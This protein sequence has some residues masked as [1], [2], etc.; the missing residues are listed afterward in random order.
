MGNDIEFDTALC[1]GTHHVSPVWDC[2]IFS[3]ADTIITNTPGE[4]TSDDS[5]A[6][7]IV[8][9]VI[10]MALAVAGVM[11]YQNGYLSTGATDT[12]NVNVSV[13][14]TPAT[15]VTPDQ[16]TTVPTN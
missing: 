11:M 9:L 6:G 3:M 1:V 15:P 7:L 12:T 13:P 16:P 8:G 5:S 10:I 4:R 2:N 14:T